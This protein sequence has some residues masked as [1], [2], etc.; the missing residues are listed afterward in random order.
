[1]DT[2]VFFNLMLQKKKK[3]RKSHGSWSHLLPRQVEIGWFVESFLELH[4]EVALV[5]PCPAHYNLQGL[6]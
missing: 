1:M 5:H 2:K 3:K 6:F 4:D